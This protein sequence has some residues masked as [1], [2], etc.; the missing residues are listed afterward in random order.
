MRLASLRTGWRHT[1]FIDIVAHKKTSPRGEVGLATVT[2]EQLGLWKR[3]TPGGLAVQFHNADRGLSDNDLN[4]MTL[5]PLEVSISR[6]AELTWGGG[7][8]A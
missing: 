5:Q 3:K 4:P 2:G 7:I 8:N 1:R 6:T